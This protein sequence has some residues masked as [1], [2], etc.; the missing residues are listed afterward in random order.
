M[1]RAQRID[2]HSSWIGKRGKDSVFP[3]GPHKVKTETSA[4]GSGK[5]GEYD[6]TTED[7]KR[8]QSAGDSKIKGRPM[9]Q[10]YRY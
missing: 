10:G 5:V 1:S 8:D 2:D 6:Q 3:D 9:K 7:I 4:E